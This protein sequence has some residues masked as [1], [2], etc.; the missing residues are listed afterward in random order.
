MDKLTVL[1]TAVGSPIAHGVLK[2]LKERNDI[3]IIGTESRAVTAG[4]AFCDKIYQVPRFKDNVESYFEAL[5]DIMNYI[6]TKVPSF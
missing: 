1:V 3:H 2:G 4:N 5:H 6:G